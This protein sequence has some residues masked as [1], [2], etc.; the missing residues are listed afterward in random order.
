MS[1]A[2]LTLRKLEDLLLKACDILRGKMDASEFKHFIFGMIFLKR[3][4]DQFLKDRED[5]QKKYLKEGLR[6]DLIERQLNNP[7]KYN[8]FVPIEARWEL[9]TPLENGF[10]GIKHLKENVG[11]G[12][13]KA[14]ETLEDANTNTLEDVLK[15]VINFNQKV[16][17]KQMDDA[18]LQEFIEHFDTIPLSNEDFEFPDLLGAAYEYLIKYFADSAGKKGGEFYT[19]AEVVRTLVEIIE[20]QE[21]M[22]IYDPT[23]G[24]GG[25]LI[26]S[27]Q[28]VEE[29]GGN[30]RDLSLFGQE[31][32]GGTWAMCKMNM[33]LHG[34]LTADIRQEDTI[35]SPQHLATNGELRR[36]DRVIANPPFSQNYTKTDM[37]FKERF[38]TFMPES[39]K[40]G[41]LMFVQ[42]M[43][44][45]LKANGKMATIMPHGVLFRGGEEKECRKKIINQGLLE[46]V[47]G[48]PPGLFYGTGIPACI[49]VIN[50]NGAAD[51]KQVLF[52]NADREYKEGK[53]Q[54]HLRR[55][56]IE[57]ITHVYRHK[58]E[59]E[60]YSRLVSVEEIEGEEFN[61]NIRR[62]VDNSPPPEPHDVRAHLKGGIPLSEIEA[63]AHY[64][65]QYPGVKELLFVSRDEKYGD[66]HSEIRTKD[67]IK[68]VIEH[69]KGVNQAHQTFVSSVASWWGTNE[70]LLVQLPTSKDVFEL[71]R[72]FLVSIVDTLSPLGLL[73]EH[74]IRGAFSDY[75]NRIGS[76]LKSVSASGW[77]PEL[78]PE[79]QILSAQFPEVL[80]ELEQQKARIAELEALFASAEPEEGEEEAEIDLD[81]LEDNETGVLPKAVV[82]L[83]KEDLKGVKAEHKDIKAK[84]KTVRADLKK[85][86][87]TPSMAQEKARYQA[88]E[89][90]LTEALAEK[91]AAVEALEAKLAGYKALE[92]ELK[93]LKASIKTT[94]KRKDDL[95]A[96]ACEKITPEEAKILILKRWEV[97]LI[98]Q[99]QDYFRQH[100]QGLTVCIENLWAKYSVTVE[101]LLQARD[102]AA[103]QL[104]HFLVELG[105]ES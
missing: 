70:P 63:L 88:E 27:K 44:A 86:D 99:Y 10:K 28:Y 80:E 53:N 5:L 56:D 85:L 32:N 52:I 89:V 102:T 7:E 60:K 58:L 73:D 46:T 39:G 69:A 18:K 98:G 95:V 67:Q 8:F 3:L 24:S 41:D 66:F 90:T 1:Q 19:P 87:K 74:K 40:K 92:D 42:H 26:Q 37:K 49:L 48:L 77:G 9:E 33:V 12:L 83:I 54:N 81:T 65:Q 20:P 68:A 94:E 57:K 47:I 103:I 96:A 76:D 59:V 78:I 38:H 61:L 75:V 25:M 82:A 100:L 101:Q 35:K 16:G 31:D 55:E 104:R 29:S 50:K 15:G 51:R 93:T 13:N 72:Q 43:M 36:F 71:R 14:L 34:I 17:Q 22:E 45:V 91:E 11:S 23:A 62:Y 30:S 64:Y 84:L 6:E 21:S 105:Y 4:N 2:K 79:D 97:L